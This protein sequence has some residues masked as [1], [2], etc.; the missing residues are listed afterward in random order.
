MNSAEMLSYILN[1]DPMRQYTGFGEISLPFSLKDKRTAMFLF[2]ESQKKDEIRAEGIFIR[3]GRQCIYEEAA[4]EAQS[5]AEVPEFIEEFTRAA[6]T[7]LRITDFDRFKVELQTLFDAYDSFASQVFRDA[8][9][10]APDIQQAVMGYAERLVLLSD[11][12]QLTLYYHFSPEFM[13]WCLDI[14]SYVQIMS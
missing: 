3:N 6:D 13:E 9:D 12:L 4:F 11:P 7:S 1:S 2:I 10:L 5:D 14:C 8:S